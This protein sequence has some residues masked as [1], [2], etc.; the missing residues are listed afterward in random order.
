MTT[1][2][3]LESW[4]KYAYSENWEERNQDLCDALQRI[5]ASTDATEAALKHV[6]AAVQAYLPPDGI[7]KDEL[8]NRVIALVDPWPTGASLPDN[9][10]ANSNER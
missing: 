7:T 2:D 1:Q 3:V 5:R 8:V 9:A 10:E 4:E 6:L